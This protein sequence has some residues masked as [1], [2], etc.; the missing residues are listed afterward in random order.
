MLKFVLNLINVILSNKGGIILPYNFMNNKKIY[1]EIKKNTL[2][3]LCFS[4]LGGSS[5]T[6][7][8]RK[9]LPVLLVQTTFPESKFLHVHQIA[10][11]PVSSVSP[12]KHSTKTV[13]EGNNYKWTRDDMFL[14]HLCCAC[15]VGSKMTTQEPKRTI[16][17]SVTTT[18][19]S[20]F[21]RC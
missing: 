8:I 10:H 6:S 18:S 5:R 14:S 20:F 19:S 7:T 13:A 16:P 3:Q 15:I 21:I 4:R 12:P 2:I 9:L 11:V 17:D 1:I